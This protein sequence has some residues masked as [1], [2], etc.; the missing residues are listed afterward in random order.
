MLSTAGILITGCQAAETSA[1]V[2]AAD[3]QSF[4]AL[5]HTF[6]KVIRRHRLKRPDE[7]ITYRQAVLKVRKLLASSGFTQHPC[8]ECSEANADSPFLEHGPAV[9]A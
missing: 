1:D 7:P 5:S 6:Q 3:G 9:K 8:L 4:G 2:K